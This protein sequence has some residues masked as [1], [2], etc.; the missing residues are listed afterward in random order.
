MGGVKQE[1]SD[2]PASKDSQHM[3]S[4]EEVSFDINKSL[5]YV[6]YKSKHKYHS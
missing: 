3:D 2:A 5:S 6:Y 4:Q 1:Q